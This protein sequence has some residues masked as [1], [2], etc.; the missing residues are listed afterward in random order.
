MTDWIDLPIAGP[1][2]LTASARFLEGFAP[3]ARASAAAHQ[4]E[5]RLAFPC[6]PS[7]RPVGVHIRQSQVD[8]RVRARVVGDRRDTGNAVAHVRRI[9]SLDVDGSG[10]AE[11]GRRDPV[12]AQ[13]QRRYPGL[14][15]VGFHSPY[16]AA[17]WAVIGNRT[18]IA[19]AAM[20]KHRLAERLG[21]EVEV[22][23]ELL[24]SFP[25]PE[26]ITAL[27]HV[28]LVNEVKSR[29]LRGI[30]E[31]AL[32]GELDA[33]ALRAMPADQAIEHLRRLDGIG[34]FSAELILL[35]GAV[36]PDG[37]PTSERRLHE[38]MVSAYGPSTVD[39]HGIAERWRPYR[40][41]I[42]VLFRTRREDLTGEIAGQRRAG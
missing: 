42:S 1:F 8:G 30:A 41:W 2:D 10:F 26:V 5:L 20:I 7:W 39:L 3:A 19:H 9:L 27:E 33:G 6:A 35:R 24:P 28:P 25:G 22:H 37:F 12:V 4:G 38:E 34:P 31:A 11:V 13:L 32:A 14:R 36:H 15:P 40:T 21:V 18:R 29:R 23:G 17:C 16:E